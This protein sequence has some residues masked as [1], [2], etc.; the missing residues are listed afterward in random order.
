MINKSILIILAAKDFN[1]TEYL[2]VKSEL[3]RNGFNVFIASDANGLCVGSRGL[4]VKAD[5]SFYNMRESNFGGMIIIGGGGIKKYWNNPNLQSLILAFHKSGKT[6]GAICSAPVCIA[7][8]GI[9]SGKEAVC[10]PDDKNELERDGVFYK[11]TDV[12]IH[13]NII[14]AKGPVNAGEFISI[15][16]NSIKK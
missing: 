10:F 12:V 2:T 5:V 6:I 16:I 9:L 4:K 3:D 15:F 13:E 7:R 14:T 8:T 1:E 11:D